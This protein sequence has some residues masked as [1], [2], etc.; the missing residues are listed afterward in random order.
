MIILPRWGFAFEWEDEPRPIRSVLQERLLRSASF[1]SAPFSGLTSRPMII[2]C[3]WKLKCNNRSVIYE[4][5]LICVLETTQHPFHYIGVSIALQLRL[6]GQEF[7][8]HRSRLLIDCLPIMDQRSE[9]YWYQT[10]I[11]LWIRHQERPTGFAIRCS[12]SRLRWQR[13]QGNLHGKF[14]FPD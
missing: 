7:H 12:I 10:T 5:Y 9:S 3:Q 13:W 11:I 2:G 1:L 4:T 6:R 14:F 8:I